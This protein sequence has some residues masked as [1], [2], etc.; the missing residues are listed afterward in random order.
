M[1]SML[2]RRAHSVACGVPQEI[3][4]MGSGA[5]AIRGNPTHLQAFSLSTYYV[6]ELKPQHP[7]LT[8]M[9]KG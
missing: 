9:A 8:T 3:H 1:A 2:P 6:L 4:A 7:I 5:E